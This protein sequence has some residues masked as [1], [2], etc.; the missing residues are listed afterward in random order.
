MCG[1]DEPSTSDSE[2]IKDADVGCD[3][4]DTDP[5]CG[6]WMPQKSPLWSGGSDACWG[7]L[8]ILSERSRGTIKKAEPWRI[9]AFEL[10]CWRRLLRVP[11]TGRRS[12]HSILRENQFWVFIGRTD[13]EA[14]TP[15]LWPPDVKNWLIGKDPD[16]GKDWRREEKGTTEDEMVGWHHQF[17]GYELGQ[18]LGG[19]KGQWSL[20]CCS[21]RGSQRVRYDLVTEQQQ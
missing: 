17:N 4:E 18:T 1:L 7:V 10:W 5:W 3:P 21:P 8:Q 12:N 13:A 2:I 11:W 20:M 15:I 14:E 19:G 9:D 16:A 6:L